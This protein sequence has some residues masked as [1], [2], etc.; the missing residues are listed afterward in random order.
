MQLYFFLYSSSSFS[1]FSTHCGSVNQSPLTCELTILCCNKTLLAK[2]VVVFGLEKRLMAPEEGG[3]DKDERSE[4][5]R[6]PTSGGSCGSWSWR[7]GV[8]KAA[9]PS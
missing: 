3:H 7:Q 6:G 1:F 4:G 8:W 5:E 9:R 2:D